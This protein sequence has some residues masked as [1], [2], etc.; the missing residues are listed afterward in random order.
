[1]SDELFF[2]TSESVSEGHPGLYLDHLSD[3]L[4][5]CISLDKLCDLVSDAVVDECLR[6]DSESHVA[7]GILFYFINV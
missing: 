4:Y 3:N 6:Q 7:C 1:M 2:F 5:S